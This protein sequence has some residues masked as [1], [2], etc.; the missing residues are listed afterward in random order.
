VLDCDKV[1]GDDCFIA[2]LCL[3]TNDELDVLHDPL[4]ERAETSTALVKS[5][6]VRRRLPPVTSG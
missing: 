3:R 1:T 6:P 2:R 5:S 4:H